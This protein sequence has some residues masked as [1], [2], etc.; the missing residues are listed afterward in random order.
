MREII[1]GVDVHPSQRIIIETFAEA[2]EL[3]ELSADETGFYRISDSEGEQV[4]VSVSEYSTSE[5]SIQ[6]IPEIEP[7][8]TPLAEPWTAWDF[9][10]IFAIMMVVILAGMYMYVS[11][12]E[13]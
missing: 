5:I 10:I 11:K 8:T 4:L 7:D 3:T 12:R 6:F 1:L 2:K 13:D 9:V